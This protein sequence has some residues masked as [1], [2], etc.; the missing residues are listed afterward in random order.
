MLIGFRESR[1]FWIRVIFGLVLFALATL[2]A[3]VKPS[4]VGQ[5]KS[6]HQLV[7]A[8]VA[9]VEWWRFAA[10]ILQGLVLF[11]L[12]RLIGQKPV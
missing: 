2:V 7:S 5:V 11:F 4:D 8:P 3:G 6:P 10:A 9:Q 12:L 1:G